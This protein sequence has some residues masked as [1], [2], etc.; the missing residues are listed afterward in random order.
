MAETIEFNFDDLT[1]GDLEKLEEAAGRPAGQIIADY[2]KDLL[3]VKDM[4]ALIYV[5]K[6][7]TDPDFTLDDARSIK[8]TA[9]SD[10]ME[11]DAVPPADAAG[12]A[13]TSTG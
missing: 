1:F 11:D 4:I 7:M 6:S 3:T 5:I 2:E 13:A 8:L 12:G 9:L 10:E